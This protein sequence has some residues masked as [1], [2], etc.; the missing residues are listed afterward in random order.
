MFVAEKV[1][2][3]LVISLTAYKHVE[4]RELVT[5]TCRNGRGDWNE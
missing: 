1:L 3:I 5:Q 2:L 4:L